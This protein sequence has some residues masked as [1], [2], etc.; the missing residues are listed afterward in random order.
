[1]ITSTAHGKRKKVII[2]GGPTASGKTS[3]AIDLA[4]K[5]KT[6]IISC[7]S[8][9]CYREMNIGVAKPSNEELQAV[10]HHF[11][12]SHSVNDHV[13]A[14]LYESY[15]LD[16]VR[17]I[18]ESS[19]H[20][21]MVGGTGL[22]IRAFAE[23]I[24]HIPPIDPEIRKKVIGSFE[25]N[26]IEWLQNEVKRLD[27][28]YYSSGEIYNPQRLMRAL[29]VQTGT[30]KSIREFQRQFPLQREFDIHKYAIAIDRDTIIDRINKR[31]EAMIQQGLVDEVEALFRYRHLAPLR[32]VGYQEIF[33]HFDGNC[34]LDQAI[35]QIK[36]N[37]RQYAKRQVTWFRHHG[38]RWIAPGDASEVIELE[39]AH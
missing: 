19:D 12:N 37:T 28:A 7:D 17:K 34:A 13:N 18:F 36:I 33:E 9:Q 20:A 26:G 3:L 24:D 32:T 5:L 8:R 10:P 22:Y 25:A 1:M 4:L 15:A 21:V 29:E 11:I 2:I 30:G 38:F 14:A 27:P 6:E 39:N 16:H 23:G 35:E 31:V